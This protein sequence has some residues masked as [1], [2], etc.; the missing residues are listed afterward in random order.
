MKTLTIDTAEFTRRADAADGKVPV[1]RL[2]RLASLLAD[3][4]GTLAW[5]LSGRVHVTPEGTRR[6]L[7]ALGVDGE[8]AM[9]CVRCLETIRVPVSVGREF[10][11][12]VSE[13]QAEREHL[14]DEQY[15]VL[16][17]D[18]L[19]D[20][21]ALVEDEAIMALPLA[22]AHDDCSPP[23][24]APGQSAAGPEPD[25][26]PPRENPFAVLQRLKR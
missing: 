3:D 9:Q 19:F 20:V 6:P 21:L 24:L 11:L 13:S 22:P 12:V 5:K 8:V 14:E 25:E 16:V 18:R 15:D 26:P 1:A 7:L 4:A 10:R 23:A 17:G 2:G